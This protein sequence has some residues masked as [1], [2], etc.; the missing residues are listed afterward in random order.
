MNYRD[1]YVT[2]D[3]D[4]AEFKLIKE[5]IDQMNK[6][7]EHRGPDSTGKFINSQKLNYRARF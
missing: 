5:T 7:Q 6:S 2:V 1:R 4:D 3:L